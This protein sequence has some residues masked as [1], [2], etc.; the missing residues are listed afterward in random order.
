MT[1]HWSV[2]DAKAHLS[3]LLRRARK[4]EPQLIGMSEG[5]VLV[6]EQE[7]SALQKANLGAWLVDSAPHGEPIEIPSR[8]SQRE[9]PFAA[10]LDSKRR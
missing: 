3:E 7:W 6:S 10:R 1:K 8:V 4:G 9:V 5:C 2:Q